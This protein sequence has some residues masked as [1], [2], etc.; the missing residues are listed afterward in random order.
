VL[1]AAHKSNA[2]GRL[3]GNMRLGR[4]GASEP[5]HCEQWL[6]L[7]LRWVILVDGPIVGADGYESRAVR[8]STAA[9]SLQ[10]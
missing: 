3:N 9:L 1:L 4:R 5:L 2:V 7:G 6:V 10:L 8:R